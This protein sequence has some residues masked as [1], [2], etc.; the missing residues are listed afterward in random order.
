MWLKQFRA[1]LDVHRL[2]H[3]SQVDRLVDNRLFMCPWIIHNS[4]GDTVGIG[5]D[6]E[7]VRQSRDGIAMFSSF[8]AGSRRRLSTGVLAH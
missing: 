3:L 7:I 1:V 6:A 8:G 4:S 2:L 5:I